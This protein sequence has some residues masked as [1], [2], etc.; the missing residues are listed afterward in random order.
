MIIVDDYDSE[1]KM[2]II[3]GEKFKSISYFA[4]LRKICIKHESK[5]PNLKITKIIKQLVSV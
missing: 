5:H 3:I 2:S 1:I 4:Q